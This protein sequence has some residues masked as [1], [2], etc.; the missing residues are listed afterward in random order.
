MDQA[1]AGSVCWN[2]FDP[3]CRSSSPA[4]EPSVTTVREPHVKPIAINELRPTQI[5]V[6]MRE[7]AA[8]RA[9]WRAQGKKK[10]ANFLG[11]HMTP[12]VL[13]PNGPHYIIDHHH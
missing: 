6:G 8:K 3:I 2:P 4:Q 1:R 11:K 12:A 13:G 5:T 10:G 7:V 9:R